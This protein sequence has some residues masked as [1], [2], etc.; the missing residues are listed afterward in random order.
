MSNALLW[1][2]ELLV[3]MESH[4][5]LSAGLIALLLVPGGLCYWAGRRRVRVARR[6]DLEQSL[7][8]IDQRLTQ[9]SS[10]VELLTDT[11]ES[12]LRTAFAEIERLSASGHAAEHK[13]RIQQRVTHSARRGRTAREIALSEGVSEGEVRLRMRLQRDPAGLAPENTDSGLADETAAMEDS[14]CRAAFTAH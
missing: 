13:A 6:K 2:A 8:A 11:T 7:A 4:V 5:L 12:A 1:G 10:A 3:W 9:L 14:T